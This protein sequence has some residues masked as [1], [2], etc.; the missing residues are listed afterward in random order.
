M[1]HDVARLITALQGLINRDYETNKV[2]LYWSDVGK[3]E[4]WKTYLQQDGKLFAGMKEVTINSFDTF[5][6]TFQKQLKECGM[7]AWDP[8]VP[9]TANV[10][11]TIC[12]LD[13]YLPVKYD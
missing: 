3:D 13:G 2:F 12:G 6:I 10:A 7:I 5:L 9:A 4:F 8:K 11:T 1:P